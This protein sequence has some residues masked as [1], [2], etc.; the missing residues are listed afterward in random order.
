MLFQVYNKVI[1]LYIYMYLFFFRFSSHLG[2]LHNVEQS[3]LCYTVG[4]CWL[5]ILNIAVMNTF[6]FFT[7]FL[8]FQE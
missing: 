2:L 1:Q 8:N 6:F 7:D 3:S 4:P 5:S